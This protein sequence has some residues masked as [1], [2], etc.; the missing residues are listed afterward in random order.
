MHLLENSLRR[1]ARIDDDRLLGDR[2]ADDRTVTAEGGNREGLPNQSS[3][4]TG[5]LQSNKLEAQA[6][7]EPQWGIRSDTLMDLDMK[8]LLFTTRSYR[9]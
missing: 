8:S 6:R 5:M 1:T 7:D 9:P 2:I 4:Y 3:H